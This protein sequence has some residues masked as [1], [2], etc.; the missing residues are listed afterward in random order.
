MSDE[1]RSEKRD[2]SDAGLPAVMMINVGVIPVIVGAPGVVAGV[3]ET[4]TLAV[5]EPMALIARS[6]T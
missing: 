6:W 4:V 3:P 2:R 1:Q 5:P